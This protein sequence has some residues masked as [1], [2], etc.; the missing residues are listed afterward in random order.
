MIDDELAGA[1]GGIR[2]EERA[3]PFEGEDM[4]RILSLSD[5]IFSFAMT[6][7][8][9]SLV[10]PTTPLS[11]GQLGWVL[12]GYWRPAVSY[13]VGFLII[14]SY[15]A[16]HHRLF[17]HLRRWDTGLIWLNLLFLMTIAVDP[18]IIGLYMVQGADLWSVSLA[19][20]V[21]AL[22]GGLLSAIWIY[23]S[24]GHR[25]TE[26]TLSDLYRRQYDR[27]TFVAPAVFALS[28]GVAFVNATA[29]EGV[30]V[31]AVVAQSLLRRRLAGERHPK[32]RR[33]SPEPSAALST[34]VR[35]EA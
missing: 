2:D 18:F 31:L 19:A 4:G 16:G 26:P 27:I 32:G 13:V 15:W 14:G 17:R 10:I 24:R 1:P 20:S 23:A 34:S 25:L 21:W 11:N 6:L 29:A 5:G 9:L 30:W 12:H 35:R 28:I 8:V 3:L 33:A 7:L 22:S